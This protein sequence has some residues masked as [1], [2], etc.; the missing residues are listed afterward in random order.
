MEFSSVN[1]AQLSE[2][3]C[4]EAAVPSPGLIT[5][6]RLLSSWTDLRMLDVSLCPVRELQS[7]CSFCKLTH[8]IFSSCD[9]TWSSNY[10]LKQKWFW[11]H[12]F[13]HI[14][15]ITCQHCFHYFRLCFTFLT[16]LIILQVQ[17]SGNRYRHTLFY[18]TS[19]YYVLQILQFL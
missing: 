12:Y 2:A 10:I 5:C 1:K 11:T 14:F 9:F 4:S 13:L 17:T 18:C 7:N 19:I 15:L 16:K 6:S 3:S 8:I